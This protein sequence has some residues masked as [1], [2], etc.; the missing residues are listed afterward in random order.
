[1]IRALAL[2]FALSA[3]AA[4]ALAQPAPA[5]PAAPAAPRPGMPDIAAQ[6]AAIAK[7]DWMVGAW[8]GSGW[9]D[10]PAGRQ[11]FRQTEAIE[12][13]LGDGLLL[14]EGKGYAGAPEALVFNAF[15]VISFDDRAGR[16]NFRSYTRGHVTDAQAVF[17]PNGAFQ[18]TMTPPGTTI[19]YTI[20]QPQPGKWNEVGERSADGGATWTKFFEM[21]LTK[22]P[23]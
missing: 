21:N 3:L 12:K 20:T 5:P 22:K 23:G 13:R 4:P 11:T 1:M 14:V 15:A 7:L 19:R 9:I 18:W 8:E 10:S 2:T 17:L 16:Y 6:K